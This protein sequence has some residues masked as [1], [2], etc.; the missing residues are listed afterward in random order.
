[1]GPA[2]GRGDI[3]VGR[4]KVLG[5]D[6]SEGDDLV[7]SSSVSS[8]T[9]RLDRQQG[10]E[11]LGDLVVE[12]GGSDLLDVNVIGVLEDLDLVSGDFTEDSDGETRS[13]EGM[14]S[15]KL[16]RDTEQSSEGSDLV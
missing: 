15:D 5:G 4:H 13:G 11:S 2:R 12:T 9:D 1:M 7:I 14:S 3:P 6:S 8:D 10:D 16:S